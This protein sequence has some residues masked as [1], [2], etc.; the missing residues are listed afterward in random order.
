MLKT[1]LFSLLL[2]S[3]LAF[4]ESQDVQLKLRSGADTFGCVYDGQFNVNGPFQIFARDPKGQSAGMIPF[5]TSM[6]N[7]IVVYPY[8]NY[9]TVVIK[10]V[11][12]P[13]RCTDLPKTIDLVVVK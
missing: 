11:V 7:E 10:K 13:A 4:A 2:L 8:E 5:T 12:A 3:N 9:M 6:A 1:I